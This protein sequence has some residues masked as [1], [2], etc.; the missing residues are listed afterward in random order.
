MQLDDTAL[1]FVVEYFELL[2]N[3][4]AR[5]MTAYTET[6]HVVVHLRDRPS[7]VHPPSFVQH[8]PAG[9]RKILQC[10]G[11]VISGLLYVHVRSVLTLT[12]DVQHL[13]EAFICGLPD[14]GITILYHSIHINPILS[15][16]PALPPPK[17]A[18][19]PEIPVPKAKPAP[20]EAPTI[21]DFVINN[22]VV[23]KN[24][25]F[26]RAAAEYLPVLVKQFGDVVRYA[27]KKGCLAAEF[28]DR[29]ARNKAVHAAW[30]DWNGRVAKLFP[31]KPDEPWEGG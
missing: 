16:T 13:D 10:S 4:R 3:S 1:V 23:V 25:P 11:S 6:A 24:L 21:R 31:L 22:S 30:S 8:I 15:E 14:A 7:V 29:A 9:T 28:A 20:V 2:Q 17:P 5:L 27:Q 26:A 18:P 12:S 19:K